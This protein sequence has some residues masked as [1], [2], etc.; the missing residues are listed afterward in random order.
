MFTF[1][2]GAGFSGAMFTKM[3]SG[4]EAFALKGKTAPDITST[5]T[6]DN[7]KNLDLMI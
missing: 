3:V 4:E 5:A 1:S 6:K 2:P 7:N